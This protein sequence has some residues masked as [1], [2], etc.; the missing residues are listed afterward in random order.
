MN[1]GTPKRHQGRDERIN[2]LQILASYG[3]IGNTRAVRVVPT[4]VLAAKSDGNVVRQG[5]LLQHCNQIFAGKK[6]QIRCQQRVIVR[7]NQDAS[8]TVE[9]MRQK[10]AI[11]LGNLQ[12]NCQT[13]FL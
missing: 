7:Q 5:R 3:R 2:E 4:R 6:S 1:L 11:V 9:C 10:C 8:G 12:D 13:K